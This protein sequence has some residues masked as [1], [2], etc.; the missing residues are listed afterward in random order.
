MS[1]LRDAEAIT[2]AG[3]PFL[4]V[5]RFLA[6]YARSMT[7]ENVRQ[8][9]LA[10]AGALDGEARA[11]ELANLASVRRQPLPSP[12]MLGRCRTELIAQIG[13][14]Q[15]TA[16][17]ATE[18]PD[19]YRRWQRAIG[20]Y[21]ITSIFARAGVARLH[22][23]HPVS[24]NAPSSRTRVQSYR[25]PTPRPAAGTLLNLNAIPRDALQRPRLNPLQIAQLL[26]L[27]AP[28]WTVS[29]DA[30]DDR[31]G[32]PK[33][34]D[35]QVMIDPHRPTTYWYTS[36]TRFQHE[37]LLQLNYVIWFPART[38]VGRFD[39]LAGR[40]DG[41]TW[42][43]TLDR[44]GTPL[45]YDSMHNCG[46]YHQFYPTSRLRRR[47]ELRV[48][49]EPLWVPLAVSPGPFAVHLAAGSHY[50][51]AIT[52][53]SGRGVALAVTRYDALRSL[54]A[55]SRRRGIFGNDGVLWGSERA[56]RFV[57]WPLGVPAPGAM[58][59]RGHHAT[60]FIGRRHFDNP[61]LLDRYFQRNE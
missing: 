23:D 33:W 14:K 2:P 27:H 24:A 4:R 51:A 58:R 12:D 53:A 20:L 16:L 50:I 22:R 17:A 7:D 61:D 18:V 15:L 3:F 35:D 55:G 59:S 31:V 57:L 19:E 37:V 32:E 8:A 29:T 38:P 60:A 49:E 44:D 28:E 40:I 43:V 26:A 1:G 54:P 13:P 6:S 56:E 25:W 48:A 34:I 10:E 41:L 42:R 52:P 30:I 9:W 39:L 11:V 46:C 5:D 36:F 21:P 47:H 45:L